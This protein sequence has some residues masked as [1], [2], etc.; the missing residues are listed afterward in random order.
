MSILQLLGDTPYRILLSEYLH[1][2]I[3]WNYDY[4]IFLFRTSHYLYHHKLK[5]RLEYWPM[6]LCINEDI[7]R[8][9]SVRGND[10]VGRLYAGV[11]Q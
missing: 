8:V 4:Y 10:L 11:P 5:R 9:V 7:L 2:L 1:A 6:T 3:I